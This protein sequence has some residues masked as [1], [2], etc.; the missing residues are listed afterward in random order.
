MSLNK[1]IAELEKELTV[2]TESRRKEIIEDFKMQIQ[3]AIE[4]GD[5]EEYLL[6]VLGEPRKVAEKFISEQITETEPKLSTALSSLIIAFS[7]AIF[8]VP[9]A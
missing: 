9:I 6:K 1:F 4:L 7:F 3:R 2:L 5:T 8:S